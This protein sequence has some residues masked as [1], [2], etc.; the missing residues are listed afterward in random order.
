[1]RKTLRATATPGPFALA[2][3]LLLL[4]APAGA[5]AAV[6]P[7]PESDYS[8][9]PACAAPA[10]GEAGC[11]ALELVPQTATARAHT[12]PLGMTRSTPIRAVNAAEGSFGFRP[13]DLNAAYFPHEPPDAP[14]SAPQTIALVDAYNDPNAEADLKVYDKE[15]ELPECTAADKCFEKLNQNGEPGNL[16]F[17]RSERELETKGTVKQREEA[18]GWVLEIS[19]DIEMAHAVCQNCHILLLEANTPAYSNFEV[20]EDTAVRVGATEVS[21]SWAGGEPEQDS[22][23]FNHP[24][25][26]ITA[27]SGDA[28]YLNW[29]EAHGTTYYSGADYPASSP[30]VVSVGGTKLTLSGGSR[31]SESVWNEDPAPDGKDHG[32]GGGGCSLQFAAAEWQLSVPDWSLVG[33]ESRR[34]VADVAAVAD[35]YT[36]VAVYDSTL[37]GGTAPNWVSIGGTSVASPII[38]SMFALAGGAH[39]VEYPARTLYSH[40]GSASLYDVTAQGN[41]ECDGVYSSCKGSISPLSP[42]DCGQGVLICNATTGYDGPSGVGTPNGLAAFTPRAEAGSQPVKEEPKPAVASPKGNP[43]EVGEPGSSGSSS[44]S[45]TPLPTV[46][47]SGLRLTLNAVAALNRG[48]P[49]V[50]LVAFA[51]TLNV[52]ARVRVTLALRV[53][54]RG[55]LRWRQLPYSLTITATRGRNS[56]HLTARGAL[57]PGLYQLTLTPVHGKTRSMVFKVG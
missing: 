31:R 20:A 44:P 41:G 48:R 49:K 43:E 39:G 8:V 3:A 38:A 14:A 1:M 40:L 16:P 55:H 37:Y 13:Q 22:P 10:P 51:F 57:A 53:R 30:H 42:L 21:D 5:A 28:G 52:P 15:F 34:A 17:P 19:T 54:V 29:A 36:G 6:S 11:L 33:C 26:V 18:E 7:L 56:R 23:A 25:V 46:Q 35:P 12:H 45:T 32:A 2:A 9:R 24:G 27:S 4:C 50:S 47:L